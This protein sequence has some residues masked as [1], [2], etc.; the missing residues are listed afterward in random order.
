MKL[1]YSKKI[2]II[3]V[4]T[5]LCVL[6]LDIVFTNLLINKIYSINDKVKQ[7][8]ISSR[9]REK[10]L[11]LKDSISSSKIEREKLQRYFV[12]AGDAETVNF[13]KYLEA[14][15]LEK[16]VSQTK[17]LAYEPAVG[18]ETSDIVSAIRFRFSLSGQWANVFSFIKAIENLPKVSYIN[19]VSV[20]LNSEAPSAKGGRIWSA[21]ID[22]SVIK[23]KN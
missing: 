12:G 4:V 7:L 15:A 18:L 10:E 13:T 17:T 14:L 21:D 2:L 22:F 3:S 8:D 11:N 19:S 16:G 9:E 20:N 1:N 23:L 5:F 6:I